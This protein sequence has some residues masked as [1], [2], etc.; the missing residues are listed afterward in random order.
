MPHTAT[1]A[2]AP[3][4]A[5]ATTRRD[6][7]DSATLRRLCVASDAAGALQTAS[8]L[9]AL[10]VTGTLLW[11]AWGGAWAIALFMIHGTL[12]NFLYAGQHEL[13]HGTVFRTRWLNEWVGRLF[14]FVLFLSEDLRS[15]TAHGRITV[16]PRIG[17][18]M[19]NSHAGATTSNRTCCG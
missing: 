7:V 8:Q 9:T 15:G 6:L 11:L 17:A 2:A 10:G 4:R 12:L 14:G 16:T 1:T 5:D 19:G 18:A 13:S 3:Q